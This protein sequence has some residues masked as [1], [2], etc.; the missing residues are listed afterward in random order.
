[1]AWCS[2]MVPDCELVFSGKQDVEG[3]VS[4]VEL[5]MLSMGMVTDEAKSRVVPLVMRGK[6]KA[7]FKGLE[8]LN[9]QSW[10]VMQARFIQDFKQRISPPELDAKLKVL[11]QDVIGEFA[12]FLK[13]FEDFWQQLEAAT[14]SR[15]N[16]Y[17]KLEKFL[18]WLYPKIREKVEFAGVEAYED[19]VYVAKVK[20]RKTK[21]KLEMG[22][23]KPSDYE[24]VLTTPQQAMQ[25]KIVHSCR[26][27]AVTSS[28]WVSS[29]PYRVSLVPPMCY[30]YMP[31]KEDLISK[32]EGCINKDMHEEETEDVVLRSQ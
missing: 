31:S 4:D 6:A 12:I 9:R 13:Q 28:P 27:V 24:V 17:F 16:D 3:W 19:A 2:N 7:W 14:Q 8:V 29:I 30:T 11:K 20:S 32:D 10:K 22:L 21:K 1:M 25:V 23:L 15:G 18:E 5:W 26:H